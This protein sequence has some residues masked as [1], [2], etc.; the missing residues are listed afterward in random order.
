MINTSAF[1]TV[2]GQDEAKQKLAFYLNSYNHTRIMPNLMLCAQKGQGKSLIAKETAKQLFAY[3]EDGTPLMKEDGVTPKKKNF[4]TITGS[5]Y[6]TAN[7]FVT[8]F[9]AKHVVD[10]DCTVFIDEAHGLKDPVIQI[11]LVLLNP[12]E[13]NRNLHVHN[14]YHCDIDF[15]RQTFILATSESHSVFAPLMDRL[16]RIDLQAYTHEDLAKI[17]AISAPE[18]SFKEG[19]LEKISSVVRGNARQCVQMANDIRTYLCGKNHFGQKNWAELCQILSIKPL[20]LSPIEID[21]LRFMQER[22]QGSSLTNLAARSGLSRD[23]VQKD[24]E[25]YLQ[26]QGLMEISAGKGRH[27]TAK[28]Q[29]YLRDLEAAPLAV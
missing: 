15:R 8:G 29:D 13:S 14:D 25:S 7:A 21:L 11:L 2:V 12:N 28:G 16:K 10:R 4:L 22:P 18:V 3:G 6:R 23:A 19:V 26:S 5:D 24:Y 9:L 20:G 17:V 27:L 1:D